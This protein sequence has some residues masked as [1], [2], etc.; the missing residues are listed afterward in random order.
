MDSF[1]G[2]NRSEHFQLFSRNLST[3]EEMAGVVS[4]VFELMGKTS[5]PKSEEE[6]VHDR[7]EKIFEVSQRKSRGSPS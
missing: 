7:V 4:S 5:D 6:L 3:R 2:K 1:P